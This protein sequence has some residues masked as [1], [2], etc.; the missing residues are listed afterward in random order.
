MTVIT[1]TA[2]Y[3]DVVAANEPELTKTQTCITVIV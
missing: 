1:N 3:L 2:D